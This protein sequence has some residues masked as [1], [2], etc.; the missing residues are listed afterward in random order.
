MGGT[1]FADPPCGSDLE[2]VNI[3]KRTFVLAGAVLFGAL[4]WFGCGKKSEEITVYMPDGAP[5]LAL[6]KLM[7]EDTESDGVSYRVVD[8]RTDA[9]ALIS[10]VTNED[11]DVNADLC[12]LPISAAAQKLGSG[13]AYKMVGLVTQGNLYLVSKNATVYDKSNVQALNGKLIVVNKLTD[14]PGLT[15][16]AAL[17]RNGLEWVLHEGSEIVEDK[18]HLIGQASEYDLELVA[19]PAVSARMAKGYHIAGNLQELY[20]RSAAEDGSYPQAVLV[21]KTS[22]VEQKR[23]WL[24]SFLGK[25]AVAEDW[26]YTAAA[27]EI[28][29]AVSSHYVDSGKQPVFTEAVLTTAT[30]AR[31]GISFAYAKD[32]Q[33]AVEEYLTEVGCA[34][35]S[36]AFYWAQN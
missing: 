4:S 12:V 21:A 9:R 8:V 17:R 32:C 7:H 26:L 19:E 2:R 30:I 13:E 1:R 24:Q 36:S 34:L 29:T 28:Y 35:P 15:L 14:V 25:V 6:A 23:T 18:V 20:A 10:K 22:I 33:N 27:E 31:C 3:K 11:P 5:A 16:K